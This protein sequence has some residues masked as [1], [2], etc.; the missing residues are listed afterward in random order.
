[1][2]KALIAGAASAVLAAM[3]VVGVF[4]ETASLSGSYTDNFQVTIERACTFTR[5]ATTPHTAGQGWDATESDYTTAT[6][7]TPAGA[8]HTLDLGEVVS[9]RKYSLGTSSFNVTCNGHNGYRV[10]AVVTNFVNS[11]NDSIAAVDQAI[12]DSFS[13]SAWTIV[14]DSASVNSTASGYTAGDEYV[15]ATT[16]PGDVVAKKGTTTLTAGE[17]FTMTYTLALA[18]G[19][20]SGTYNGSVSYTLYDLTDTPAN[21]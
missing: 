5:N 21:N 2:K 7:Q 6:W 17:P 11:T 13:T 18:D 16:T 19:Q 1:M 3:P 10:N 20:P 4:A 15:T 14:S 8:T 12:G 9:G